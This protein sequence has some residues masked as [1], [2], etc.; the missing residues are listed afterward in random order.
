MF[1][2]LY[3]QGHILKQ[4]IHTGIGSVSSDYLL[5]YD[6]ICRD[7]IRV[8]KTPTVV[9]EILRD[10]IAERS[11]GIVC[12]LGCGDGYIIKNI[13]A[14]IKVAVDIAYPYLQNLPNDIIRIYGPVESV[15]LDMRSIDT[16]ICTDVLE[17]VLSA[18]MVASEINCLVKSDGNILLAFPY[19]QDLS[20]Y[21]LPEYKKNQ[22]QYKYV[23]LRSIDDEFIA[24]IFPRFKVKFEQLI[25]DG[26]A[27]MKYKPYPI[28]FL[29]LVRK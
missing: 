4:I 26:M 12:D 27:E 11:G 9:K 28:K 16:V 5:N 2:E 13:D 14:D 21:D 29:E 24:K 6:A 20:V 22:K 18:E 23:H 10:L 15:P 25:E 8:P 3:K 17:H 7:D 19:K 1:M